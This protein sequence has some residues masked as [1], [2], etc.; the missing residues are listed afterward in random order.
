MVVE[1][2]LTIAGCGRGLEFYYVL[3]N[4]YVLSGI[5]GKKAALVPSQLGCGDRESCKIHDIASL[6]TNRVARVG[7]YNV[8]RAVYRLV[9]TLFMLLFRRLFEPLKQS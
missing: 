4:M 6:K 1:Q 5:Q 8:N 3:R 7:L 2:T 9:W